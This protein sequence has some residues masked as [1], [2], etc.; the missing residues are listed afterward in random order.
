[1]NPVHLPKSIYSGEWENT[2]H[3]QGIALDTKR[4]YIYYSF[5]TTLVKT[6]L[7]GNLI[8]TVTGL[9]GH[10]GCL[11]FNDG[12]GRLYG[13]LEYKNDSIGKGILSLYGDRTSFPDAFYIAIF[14]VDKIDRVGMDASTDGVMTT[15][16]LKTVVD[17]FNAT[18]VNGGREVRHALGCS[19][20]DGTTFG[21]M[22][23]SKDGKN[24]LFV[25]YGVYSDRD[26]TDN[27]YQVILCYD[28][29]DWKQYEQPLYQDSMHVSGPDAPCRKLFVYTGNTTYGV[30]NLEYDAHT[31]NYLMAVYRGS[32]PN[33]PN[34]SFYVVDGSKAPEMKNLRG[35]EPEMQG[36]VLELL[37]AGEYDA[38]TDTWG[39]NF[40]EGSTGMYSLGDGRFYISEHGHSGNVWHSNVR[41]Y[42]WDGIS[43]L[44]IVE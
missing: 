17:D 32:K 2:G 44:K 25:A 23:G 7:Q 13:S 20:I 39:F 19:G 42:Q 1:M 12:D 16:W 18:V 35:V 6:D 14:D 30:Q 11:A 43:P 37:R 3:C 41:L 4:E 34:Y 28:V 8:G 40:P 5:T 24:Y 31:G 9:R 29:A 33:Y 22:P 10:L 36:E 38:A 27:D 26:R 15:V 21:P